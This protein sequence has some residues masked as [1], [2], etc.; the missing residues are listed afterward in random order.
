[1][2]MNFSL[3]LYVA[4]NICVYR[5]LRNLLHLKASPF[6]TFERNL[7]IK[8]FFVVL[9]GDPPEKRHRPYCTLR[10]LCR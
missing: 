8:T 10:L 9:R 7:N 2:G 3:A 4:V 6:T 1:M 5:L